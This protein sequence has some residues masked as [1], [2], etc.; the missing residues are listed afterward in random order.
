MLLSVFAH[1]WRVAGNLM[2]SSFFSLLYP[3]FIGVK[4]Y[5]AEEHFEDFFK[6]LFPRKKF[7]LLRIVRCI[8]WFGIDGI[9][10]PQP[11][12]M[13]NRWIIDRFLICCFFPAFLLKWKKPDL[14][15]LWISFTVQEFRVLKNVLFLILL[16]VFARHWCEAGICIVSS[17]FGCQEVPGKRTFQRF[18][19]KLF[20]Q[21]PLELHLCRCYVALSGVDGI[22]HPWPL[23]MENT[24]INDRFFVLLNFFLGGILKWKKPDLQFFWISFSNK[25]SRIL[26]N[27]LFFDVAVSL[28]SSF[29]RCG[30]LY[31]VQ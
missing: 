21:Q 14:Q 31:G 18:F 5:P 17:D 1:H 8:A 10:H 4:N 22:C 13:E 30:Q 28:C 16:S 24:W 6:Q 19:L 20:P 9:C 2:V 15:F 25:E 11:S 12:V 26:I 3:V 29:V 7:Q 23:A 27:V